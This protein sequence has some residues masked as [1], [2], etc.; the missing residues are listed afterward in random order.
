MVKD[1]VR[2]HPLAS[3]DPVQWV[4]PAVF[5]VYCRWRGKG[6]VARSEDGPARPVGTNPELRRAGDGWVALS[7]NDEPAT[8]PDAQQSLKYFTVRCRR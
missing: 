2:K 3:E 1:S 5:D 7:E 4:S 8:V 6:G